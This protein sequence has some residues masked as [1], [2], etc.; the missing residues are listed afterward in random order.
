MGLYLGATVIPALL[1]ASVST[2]IAGAALAVRR[3][4][5]IRWPHS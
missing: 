2:A 1:I 5:S 4:T 3:G